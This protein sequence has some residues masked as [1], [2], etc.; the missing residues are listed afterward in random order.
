MGLAGELVDLRLCVELTIHWFPHSVQ[1]VLAFLDMGAD[2]TLLMGI[3]TSF[4]DPL[5]PQKAM[6]V[7]SFA[8]GRSL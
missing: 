7:V 6:E 5:Q 2:S 1:R 4:Q 3:W 8:C